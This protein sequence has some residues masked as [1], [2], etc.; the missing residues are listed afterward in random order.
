LYNSAALSLIGDDNYLRELDYYLGDVSSP[1]SQSFIKA[2]KDK[3]L[4]MKLCGRWAGE[5]ESRIRHLL[6]VWSLKFLEKTFVQGQAYGYGTLK[7]GWT[8]LNGESLTQ[9]NDCFYSALKIELSS[10]GENAP[11]G[12]CIIVSSGKGT[13]PA[14]VN[15]S[16][17][18]SYDSAISDSLP[19]KAIIRDFDDYQEEILVSI[20]AS[21]LKKAGIDGSDLTVAFYGYDFAWYDGR[22]FV[23]VVKSF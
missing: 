15:S 3:A 2:L 18:D 16:E 22:E 14:S 20:T 13:A 12:G 10:I 21:E 19:E 8:L 23:G 5:D 6:E 17:F 11:M 9:V 7:V 4:M 1:L